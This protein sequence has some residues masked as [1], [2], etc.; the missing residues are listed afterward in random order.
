MEKPTVF[1]ATDHAG[2]DFKNEL[3]AYVRDVLDYSVED[4]G[5]YKF[6]ESD[7]YPDFV[8]VA[9]RAVSENP[10]ERVAIVIGAS[11]QGE[12]MCANRHK[13]VRAALYYGTPQ[14]D[15]IDASGKKL[16]MIESSRIHNAAN[17]L[18]LGARFVAVDEAKEVVQKWLATPPATE[19]RHLRRIAK[20][21]I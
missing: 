7:D 12:A 3:L 18:S 17:V 11:G 13:G 10:H 4:C 21:D 2:L 14:K 16:D 6:D 8:H 1:F 20:L 19:A 9:A 15:Q 5:A